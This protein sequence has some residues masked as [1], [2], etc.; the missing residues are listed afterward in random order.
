MKDATRITIESYDRI[1]QQF[2]NKVANLHHTGEYEKFLGYVPEGGKILDLGCG[3]GRD[4]KV[5]SEKGY[6]VT[7][8]D[9]S[10]E[11][12]KIARETAPKAQFF[13]MDILY[14]SYPDQTFDGIWAASS[15]L[16][17]PKKEVP[18]CLKEAYNVLKPEGALYVCVKK[19]DGEKLEPDL[20]YGPKIS[21]H[22]SYFQPDELQG[23]LEQ[24]GFSVLEKKLLKPE[25]EYLKNT[26]IRLFAKKD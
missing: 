8:I 6:E 7:G 4:A 21:R 23:M 14:L 5:F 26:E 3:S 13:E 25:S 11:L 24:A 19:G 15:I 20:R 10:K 22:Y 12:L 16:H 1:A 9:R 18:R 17:L 2:A